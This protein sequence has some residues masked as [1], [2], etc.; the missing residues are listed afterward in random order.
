MKEKDI[1]SRCQLCRRHE[2]DDSIVTA[3]AGAVLHVPEVDYD[4]PMI[5]V[6][7]A[8]RYAPFLH[9]LWLAVFQMKF[10]IAPTQKPRAIESEHIWY[11]KPFSLSYCIFSTFGSG[12]TLELSEETVQEVL[13]ACRE[14]IGWIF[15]INISSPCRCQ[16]SSKGMEKFTIHA[17]SNNYETYTLLAWEPT[18][19]TEHNNRW[20]VGITGGVDLSNSMDPSS[21][22]V[23]MKGFGI[24][25][26]W[27]CLGWGLISLGGFRI[28][29]L[30]L[31]WRTC[32]SWMRQMMLQC[33]DIEM[34]GSE[35]VKIF[36]HTSGSHGWL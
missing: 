24:S 27:S 2:N 30:L 14:D 1:Q 3:A 22:F 8:A 9:W 29:L 19:A 36:G 15:D 6:P 20:A 18:S 34:E 10:E 32:G 26:P 25:A 31:W 33:T 11:R 35:E 16:S 4:W 7:Q 17:L 23:S 12:S 21:S 13:A 28:L 5:Q